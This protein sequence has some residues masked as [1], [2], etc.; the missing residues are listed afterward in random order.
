MQGLKLLGLSIKSANQGPAS[1]S[2]VGLENSKT[3]I[4]S[5]GFEKVGVGSKAARIDHDVTATPTNIAG[6]IARISYGLI[7][8]ALAWG[9]YF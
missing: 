2:Q 1:R 3:P 5:T 7:D 9:W 8:E 4:S 6:G